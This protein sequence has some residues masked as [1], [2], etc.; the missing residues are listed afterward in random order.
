MANCEECDQEATKRKYKTVAGKKLGKLVNL[1]ICQEKSCGELRHNNINERKKNLPNCRE[2]P[3]SFLIKYAA[4][5][6]NQSALVT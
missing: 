3:F 2:L 4:K 6:F 5:A 1:G